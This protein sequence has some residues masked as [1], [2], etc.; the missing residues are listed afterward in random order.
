MVSWMNFSVGKRV[1]LLL[2]AA[3]WICVQKQSIAAVPESVAVRKQGPEVQAIIDLL[4]AKAIK[5][6]GTWQTRAGWQG[7]PDDPWELGLASGQWYV[8][9]L[10]LKPS[11]FESFQLLGS[12]D[13]IFFMWKNGSSPDPV[14]F[15]FDT[16]ESGRFPGGSE[17]IAGHFLLQINVMPQQFIGALGGLSVVGKQPAEGVELV[18][19]RAD[20][21]ADKVAAS[22]MAFV[23]PTGTV[24]AGRLRPTIDLFYDPARQ[25]IVRV[26]VS[27]ST[28]ERYRAK[29]DGWD[30]FGTA[31]Q[32]PA[33]ITGSQ[34]GP[35]T[36]SNEETSE[37]PRKTFLLVVEK[38]TPGPST[39]L[40]QVAKDFEAHLAI[41][42][43]PSSMRRPA[44]YKASLSLKDNPMDRLAL[45]EADF[46]LAEDVEG[47]LAA[48]SQ[49]D[50]QFPDQKTQRT[51]RNSLAVA[52]GRAMASAAKTP[53]QQLACAELL[54]RF[55]QFDDS[56][57]QSIAGFV[58]STWASLR[59]EPATRISVQ[60]LTPLILRKAA[61]V[62][63]VMVLEQLIRMAESRREDAEL[64]DPVLRTIVEQS[65]PL[66]GL[67]DSRQDY[68]IAAAVRAG[69]L[70]RAA[71]YIDALKF[72]PDAKEQDRQVAALWHQAVEHAQTLRTG[73]PAG[74]TGAIGT[75][76]SF[77]KLS[78][79][80]HRTD[81]VYGQL[82]LVQ[83]VE[84]LL[85]R[86]A[87]G[88]DK[89]QASDLIRQT[90][91]VGDSQMFWQAVLRQSATDNSLRPQ[92][93]F[94]V[95]G[96]AMRAYGEAFK[97]LAFESQLW[98]SLAVR[99]EIRG[100]QL[101][102]E[103]QYLNKA[104]A[105]ARDDQARGQIIVSLGSAYA[106]VREY[107]KGAQAVEGA[108]DIVQD[109]AVRMQLMS[110][111][112]YLKNRGASVMAKRAPS[113]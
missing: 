92:Y 82:V 36:Q 8:K 30:A 26:D 109:P 97:D 95:M 28:A 60:R 11:A 48:W 57:F 70:Q 86:L 100:Q 38:F 19:L 42:T 101:G 40:K 22:D 78:F 35:S 1:G 53:N 13:D 3:A 65:V 50:R 85:N 107:V 81:R 64:L 90:S 24:P 103:V 52:A 112:M 71:G 4:G 62:G 43:A 94:A 68:L 111:A 63:N 59:N 23:G 106:N 73:D 89:T 9:S 2:A 21:K 88:N 54:Q 72:Q 34:F 67:L 37:L 98:V 29:V 41:P 55:V 77:G 33:K 46:L 44:F 76:A 7:V 49:L 84:A 12:T 47:G 45:A 16:L 108:A 15:Q 20:P 18:H 66:S 93:M 32:W 91:N 61:S 104:L 58:C 27:A 96:P 31:S 51:V 56:E 6:A 5:A 79:A 80:T 25:A 99:P 75:Y 14:R 39:M 102:L 87:E 74:L 105:A 110:F 10:A 113:P 17:Y 69:T 83:A